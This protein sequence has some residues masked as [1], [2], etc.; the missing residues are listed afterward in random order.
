V[1]SGADVVRWDNSIFLSCE[2][3]SARTGIHGGRLELWNTHG[4]P[5]KYPPVKPTA[6][7]ARNFLDCV[8]GRAE[9]PCPPVWGLRQ[10]LLMEA[11]Y[12]S[13]KLGRPVKVAAE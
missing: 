10:A 13:A 2:R 12:Q 8:R 5:I 9:T 4:N 11:F 3:G 7:I 6:S 1:V